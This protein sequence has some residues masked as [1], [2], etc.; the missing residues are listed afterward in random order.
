MPFSVDVLSLLGPKYCGQSAATAQA[1]DS[2]TINVMS[3]TLALIDM[4]PFLLKQ[5]NAGIFG[6]LT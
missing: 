2:A 5:N 6:S 3:F 1:T 4:A